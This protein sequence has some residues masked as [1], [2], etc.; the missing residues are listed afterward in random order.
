MRKMILHKKLFFSGTGDLEIWPFNGPPGGQKR[1]REVKSIWTEPS[2]A[3][4]EA[5]EP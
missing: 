1:T 5:P 2:G 3:P 4:E